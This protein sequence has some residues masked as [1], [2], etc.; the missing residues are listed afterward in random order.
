MYEVPNPN[1]PER[2][3]VDVM[4]A[5]YVIG[6]RC[7]RPA[8]VAI[9]KGGAKAVPAA[10]GAQDGGDGPQKAA[11]DDFPGGSGPGKGDKPQDQGSD[12][13]SP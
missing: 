7:L 2:T 5:G 10:Q 9:A 4:Q 1:V 6:D 13:G 11:N 8:L 12:R 3:V